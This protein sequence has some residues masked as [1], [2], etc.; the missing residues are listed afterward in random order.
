M[1]DSASKIF[2]VVL[3]KP[4]HY[5]DDGYVIQWVRSSIPSNTLAT[6]YGLIMDCA[7][8]RI[9]GDDV[10]IELSAY[11]ETNSRIRVNRLVKQIKKTG[12]NALVGLIGVH[13][14]QYPRAMDIARQFRAAGVQVCIGGFH[15]SGCL[16]MLPHMPAEL[17]EALDLGIT[18]FAGELEGRQD[19]FL[20]AAYRNEL[21]PLYNY[22][23]DLPGL[24]G[25]P[26][27]YLP[28]DRLKKTAGTRTSF[29]AG[30]GCPFLCSFC[31]IINVQGR[32]SR[33]R[34]ADDV[35]HIIRIN[36][37]QG[38]T[39][40]FITDD[41]FARNKDWE[42]VFDRII[43]L[44]EVDKFHIDIIIQV[45]TMCHKIPGFIEKAGRAGVNR[46]FIGLE[47]INPD[48]LKE[49][50]KGQNRITEY[51]AMLQAWHRTGALTY[52]GYIL[53]FPGDTPESILRDIEIIQR[54]LPV[55]LLEFFILTPLP[56]SQDHKRLLEQNVPM[57]ADLNNYDLEHVT[58][59]H[60]NMSPQQWRDIY[61][62]AWDAY[63]TPAHV[64][65]VIRRAITWGF[66]PKH[67]MI[68]LLSFYACIRF[69]NIHP[70]E[71]GLARRK[72]RRDRRPGLPLEKPV[73]FHLR[74][75]GEMLSKYARF[76]WM[77][78]QYRGILKR[79]V[80]EA[81]TSSYT[82]LA[83]TPVREDELERL[84]MYTA[85]TAARAAVDRSQK[86]RRAGKQVA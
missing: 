81:R 29:D 2:Q 17:Q 80:R 30:R 65:T 45:D 13:S 72:Y 75:T 76:F 50:R 56:G 25:V 3:I 28:A 31:T 36:A 20:R 1:S 60:T 85:T 77:T 48:A 68:K 66:N 33:Y 38:V 63:Y 15:V 4:S 51:R 42:P 55:D 49:A 39:N 37:A 23:N 46:V 6:L 18:L 52:A 67:M 32:K 82:D 21:E 43:Q 12:G 35:E 83:M 26:V 27:P 58:T 11:D 62:K 34:T 54:E 61:R 24:E 47:N 14:N 22:M 69:E 53:G 79:V 16:A 74:Y 59:G 5:D 7:E 78:W 70:L 71:G 57:D 19:E 86:R 9:L 41:N 84:D 8:R 73:L 10:N 40:F 44:R 64:A